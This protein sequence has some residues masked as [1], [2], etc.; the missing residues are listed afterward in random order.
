[1]LRPSDASAPEAFHKAAIHR[2]SAQT[3]PRIPH[4]GRRASAPPLACR[5]RGGGSRGAEGK[6]NLPARSV[7]G[8]VILVT[9]LHEE[10]QE[11]D[12]HG[13]FAEFGAP[14]GLHLNLDR[15][16]GFVKGYAL[17]EYETKRE[18]QEA[19]DEMNGKEILGKEVA[20][21]W[22]FCQGPKQ[23]KRQII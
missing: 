21:S 9:G 20:V 22:A 5:G 10:A 13:E 17:I 18:A 19:I 7:E 15:Q 8:W 23:P 12:V 6:A 2:R 3:P 16:S 14:K 4:R 11:E 1:M